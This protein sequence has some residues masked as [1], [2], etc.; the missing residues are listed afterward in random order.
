MDIDVKVFLFLLAV[1][2]LLIAAA[3]CL[4]LRALCLRIGSN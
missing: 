1:W 2:Y 4:I 3:D